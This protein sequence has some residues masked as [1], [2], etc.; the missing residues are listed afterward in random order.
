MPA[1]DRHIFRKCVSNRI[2]QINPAIFTNGR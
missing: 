2:N 1:Y